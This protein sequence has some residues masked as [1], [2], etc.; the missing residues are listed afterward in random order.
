MRNIA[1]GAAMLAPKSCA[2]HRPVPARRAAAMA[3]QSVIRENRRC[4]DT[5]GPADSKKRLHDLHATPFQYPFSKIAAP[6]LAAQL[7]W[8]PE[9][10]HAGKNGVERPGCAAQKFARKQTLCV[11]SLR[12]TNGLHEPRNLLQR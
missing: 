12:D 1:D 10:Q 2:T 8:Q 9:Q 5:A 3:L 11:I 6:E 7:G 4:F